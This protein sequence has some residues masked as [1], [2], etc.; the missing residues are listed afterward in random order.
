MQ[1]VGNEIPVVVVT[2]AAALFVEIVDEVEDAVDFDAGLEHM[3]SVAPGRHLLALHAPLVGQ[4]ATLH[5]VGSANVEAGPVEVVS[6]LDRRRRGWS[7]WIVRNGGADRLFIRQRRL[8]TLVLE[9]PAI[10]KQ[11]AVNQV[12]GKHRG[13]TGAIALVDTK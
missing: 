7:Q 12:R 10:L 5:E 1:V 6:D 4:G 2:V 8:R 3:F 13:G 9:V 11:K